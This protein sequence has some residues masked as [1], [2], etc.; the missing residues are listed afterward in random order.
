MKENPYRASI[1]FN[2]DSTVLAGEARIE[3]PFLPGRELLDELYGDMRVRLTFKMMGERATVLYLECEDE[4]MPDGRDIENVV[5]TVRRLLDTLGSISSTN[6]FQDWA[7]S[8]PFD[9]L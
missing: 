7:A 9:D 3:P 1:A 2:F 6:I 4:Y 8:E 5:Y